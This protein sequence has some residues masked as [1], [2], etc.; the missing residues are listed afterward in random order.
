MAK[1]VKIVNDSMTITCFSQQGDQRGLKNAYDL[2][3]T[4]IVVL[5]NC[6]LSLKNS[7][8]VL[9]IC[10]SEVVQTLNIELFDFKPIKFVVKITLQ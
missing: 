7:W 5:E 1:E 6:N 10:L 2:T 8:N 9:E 4:N 3:E